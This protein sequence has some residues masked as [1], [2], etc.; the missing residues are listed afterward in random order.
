MARRSIRPDPL[1]L[2]PGFTRPRVFLAKAKAEAVA[3]PPPRP[4]P[5]TCR[6]QESRAAEWEPAA[7]PCP[8]SW[9]MSMS[10]AFASSPLL[11]PR[12]CCGGVAR[13][14]CA[15]QRPSATSRGRPSNR[16]DKNHHAMHHH[17][18]HHLT[19][20]LPML[21]PFCLRRSWSPSPSST[22]LGLP[23]VCSS[24]SSNSSKSS[25]GG[26]LPSLLPAPA[27][28]AAAA[29]EPRTRP[30]TATAA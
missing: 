5:R 3:P 25:V 24:S 15:S 13:P 30:T 28:R 14:R 8:R 26:V 4:P 23:I 9:S 6:I 7:P 10:L 12:T 2:A 11:L 19:T 17:H 20:T 29:C 27:A 21:P 1:E 22:M 18:H 16:F